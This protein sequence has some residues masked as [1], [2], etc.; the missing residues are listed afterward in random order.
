MIYYQDETLLIRSMEADDARRITDAELAQGW[1]VEVEKQEMRYRHQTE[2][3][4]VA[5]IAEYQGTVAGY[6]NVYHAALDGPKAFRH[7][8]EIVDFGVFIKFR[9]LGIGSRLMDTAEHVA[10]QKADAVCLGVGL[11]DGY[12]SAQRMYVKRGYI[13]DGSGVWYNGQV[14]GQYAPCCNDDDLIMYF[15]KK[16]R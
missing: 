15:S 4:S 16:L 2:G 6:I 12:G 10:A 11:H 8:P 1:H 3:K 7:L 14:C 9:R 13:P 5:L